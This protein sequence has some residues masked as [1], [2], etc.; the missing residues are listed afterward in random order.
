MGPQIIDTLLI[1]TCKN[2]LLKCKILFHN[3]IK[4]V[5][6]NLKKKMK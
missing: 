5:T 1:Y 4:S 2:N 6:P 3:L